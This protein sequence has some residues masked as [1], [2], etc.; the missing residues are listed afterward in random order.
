MNAG[1]SPK[2]AS[3]PETPRPRRRL[4]LCLDGTWNTA[5]GETITSIVRLRD[6][7]A[8]GRVEP[9]GGE[10]VEQHIY[11]DEGVGTG[12]CFRKLVDGATGRGLSRNIRQAYRYLAGNYREGDQIV[13]FGFSRGAFTARSLAGYIGASG[14][15]RPEHCTAENERRAW[16]HYRTPPKDRFP[17]ESRGLAALCFPPVR[18]S[19]L[20][21]FDTVGSLGIPG[22]LRSLSTRRFRFHDA[23]LGQNV[24][25]ALHALAADEKRHSFGPALWQLPQH[26]AYGVV[27][28]VWFP[29][30]HSDV[31]GGYAED[32]IG[33]VVLDW[34]LKRIH[35]LGKAQQ[36]DVALRPEA[37][38]LRESTP[39]DQEAAIHESRTPIFFLDRL[40]PS[41]R[42]IAQ[43][44]PQQRGRER[45]NSLPRHARPIGEYLHMTL[46]MRLFDA[47]GRPTLPNAFAPLERI[48]AGADAPIGFV[49]L[50]GR[51]YEWGRN[52]DTGDR[53]TF[54]QLLPAELH[55]PL[56]AFLAGRWKRNLVEPDPRTPF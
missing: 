5:D 37:R 8:P 35:A 47:K 46:L 25:I 33:R 56:D 12:G 49:D 40:M 17:A 50:D 7:I 51:P 11:Y 32:G 13:I 41:V 24:E 34:M 4:I 54:Y 39:T 10:P 44:R 43:Q 48:A 52:P 18:I 20:G 14:L 28:Q 53:M 31:G 19:V 55:E 3:G 36:I 9:E 26:K 23:T 30:V 1:D 2:P 27:E 29:G 22:V 38:H 21:V 16:D 42:V 15:L 6:I 45:M